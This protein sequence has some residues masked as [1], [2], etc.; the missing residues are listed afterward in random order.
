[1]KEAKKLLTL[2]ASIIL[3]WVGL[4][5]LSHYQNILSPFDISWETYSMPVLWA[6][7]IAFGIYL[8]VRYIKMER[9]S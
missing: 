9:R 7:S 3:F 8:F 1:M 5:N 2:D 6:S 4:V